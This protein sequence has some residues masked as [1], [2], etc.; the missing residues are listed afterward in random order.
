MP[1]EYVE[2]TEFDVA[3]NPNHSEPG[4]NQAVSA[5]LWHSTRN[6]GVCRCIVGFEGCDAANWS[7]GIHA[8]SAYE[9]RQRAD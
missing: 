5:V 1:D 6:V 9:W 3:L 7:R 2:M 8:E 4:A